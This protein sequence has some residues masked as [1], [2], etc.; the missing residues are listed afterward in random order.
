MFGIIQIIENYQLAENEKMSC[1]IML[2]MRTKNHVK[3]NMLNKSKECNL[4][5]YQLR[6]LNMRILIL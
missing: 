6:E 2:W 4:L 3:D 1:F 5:Y